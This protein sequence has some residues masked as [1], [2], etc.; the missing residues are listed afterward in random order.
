MWDIELEY[1]L[2]VIGMNATLN[3]N[4]DKNHA[5]LIEA[6]VIKYSW[7]RK[8]YFYKTKFFF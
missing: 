4:K 1:N 7:A 3:R 5:E 8:P 2:S 6:D